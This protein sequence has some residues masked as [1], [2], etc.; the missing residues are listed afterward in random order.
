MARW[1]RGHF[2]C[3]ITEWRKGMRPRV[4]PA[5]AASASTA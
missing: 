3:T 2:G 5:D 1:F 4:E